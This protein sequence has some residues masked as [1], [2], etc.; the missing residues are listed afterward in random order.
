AK[1]RKRVQHVQYV[2]RYCYRVLLHGVQGDFNKMKRMAKRGEF[3]SLIRTPLMGLAIPVMT[4]VV[5][6]AAIG[7]ECPEM[8]T[9]PCALYSRADVVFIGTMTSAFPKALDGDN[10]VEVRFHVD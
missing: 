3:F 1:I 6:V 4:I 7:C 10:F 9:P 8:F 5:S 2:R